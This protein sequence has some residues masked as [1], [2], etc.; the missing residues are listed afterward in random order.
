MINIELCNDEF[1]PA[2]PKQSTPVDSGSVTTGY[3]GDISRSPNFQ[4]AFRR[5]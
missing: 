3:R 4:L 5:D 1:Q 2:C